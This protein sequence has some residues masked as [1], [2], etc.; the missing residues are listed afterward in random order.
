MFAE[1][2]DMKF[3]RSIESVEISTSNPLAA[4]VGTWV[5]TWTTPDG[6]V[7]TGGRYAASWRKG[8]RGWVIRSELFVTLY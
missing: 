6:K 5:G 4:E 7:K 1:F 3:V 2:S 8:E